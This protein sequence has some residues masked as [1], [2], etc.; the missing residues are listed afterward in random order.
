M[1]E[2]E[3]PG[4]FQRRSLV[5]SEQAIDDLGDLGISC[6]LGNFFEAV[7]PEIGKLSEIVLLFVKADGNPLP[8]QGRVFRDRMCEAEQQ[9]GL[10]HPAITEEKN[11]LEG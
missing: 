4:F 5:L 3:K 10:A 9:G 11:V 2:P 6:L 7:Q 8:S 1:S